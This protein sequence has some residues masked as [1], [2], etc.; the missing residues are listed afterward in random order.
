MFLPVE[1]YEVKSTA[2]QC[3]QKKSLAGNKKSNAAFAMF[4]EVF[5]YQS[6]KKVIYSTFSVIVYS[7]TKKEICVIK[8][9]KK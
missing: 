5:I 9:I 8:K 6:P 1:I 2:Q 3:L 7:L 4:Q